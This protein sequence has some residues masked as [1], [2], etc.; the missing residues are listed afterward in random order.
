MT[1]FVSI[2]AYR[3]PE[4]VP[5]IQD[6]IAKARHPSEVRIVVC[7]QHGEGEQVDL[8]PCA[9]RLEF[10]GFD[11][12]DSRGTCWARA[13]IMKRWRGEDYY[14]QLDS[15]HRFVRDWDAK[16]A[17][18]IAIAPSSKPLLTT[19]CQDYDLNT[20]R[21]V[22]TAPTR[23]DFDSF[24]SEG[25]PLYRSTSLSMDRRAGVRPPIRARFVSAHFLFVAGSFVREV[26][27]D[28]ALYF[29]G[30]EI[31]LAVRAYSCG[32]DLFHPSE[33][34]VFHRYSRDGRAKHWDDHCDGASVERP[35]YERD[36]SSRNRVVEML[37]E[38]PIGRFAFGTCRT[39]DEYEKYAGIDFRARLIQDY[40]LN[41]GEPPNPP[42]ANWLKG[43]STYQVVI[44]LERSRL[45]EAGITCALEWHFVLRDV[46]EVSVHEFVLRP[47]VVTGI[48]ADTSPL[49]LIQ[50]SVESRAA[51][52]GWELKTGNGG[53]FRVLGGLVEATLSSEP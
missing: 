43:P 17:G 31:S 47:E 30:E 7:W 16:L 24:T 45:V 51:P 44:E 2:A 3:D 4:L 23:I 33:A 42:D 40:T 25:I 20:G 41:G 32:Y 38:R 15:H 5:T 12:R 10:L 35:W 39:V 50:L 11:W 21:P 28:P 34:V 27:Y 18:Q 6:C 46:A 22:S 49:I 1:I 26:E 48:L 13:E 29:H 14:L 36:H 52:Y 37:R 19:Y 8:V 9:G 53:A